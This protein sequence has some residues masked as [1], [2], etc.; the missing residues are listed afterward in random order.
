VALG[1]TSRQIDLLRSTVDYCA[2]RVAPDSIYA[3]LRNPA[4]EQMLSAL[5]AHR[6]EV[7]DSRAQDT[8]V[9]LSDPAGALD[10]YRDLHET[11]KRTLGD[12]GFDGETRDWNEYVQ[13]HGTEL[14]DVGAWVKLVEE[15]VLEPNRP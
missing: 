6:A 5:E 13:K 8:S 7:A 4:D 14:P 1:R 12:A 9:G 15:Q 11:W 10:R 3:V 2:E